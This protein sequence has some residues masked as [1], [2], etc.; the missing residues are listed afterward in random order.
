[1]L[2]SHIGLNREMAIRTLLT[3]QK[4]RRDWAIKELVSTKSNFNRYRKDKTSKYDFGGGI[5]G[6]QILEFYVLIFIAT[7]YL[8]FFASG[9]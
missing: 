1:M 8:V 4:G 5:L 3:W 6:H 2:P 9:G 7:V